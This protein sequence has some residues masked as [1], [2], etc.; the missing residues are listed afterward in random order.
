MFPHSALWTPGS[1]LW[2]VFPFSQKVA[3][4]K[5]LGIPKPI[6]LHF[7]PT[8]PFQSKTVKFL[9]VS[10]LRTLWVPSWNFLGSNPKATPTNLFPIKPTLSAASA[11]MIEGQCPQTSWKLC[12]LTERLCVTLLIPLEGLESD[13]RFSEA[14]PFWDPFQILKDSIA[15]L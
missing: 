3:S 7:K 5:I 4:V 14:P 2:V 10:L 1:I 15:T 8:L 11:G 9:Q 13:W 6:C 12:C